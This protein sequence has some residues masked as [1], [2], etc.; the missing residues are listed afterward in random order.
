MAKPGGHG[1]HPRNFLHRVE[2]RGQMQTDPGIKGTRL[3][4]LNDLNAAIQDVFNHHGVQIM[5]PHYEADPA[6]PKVVKEPARPLDP[7][8]YKS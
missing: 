3:Q 2:R 1:S 8:A 4:V 6:L 7:P 5:S